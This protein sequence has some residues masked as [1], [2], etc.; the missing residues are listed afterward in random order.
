MTIWN[1]RSFVI[2]SI[3]ITIITRGLVILRKDIIDQATK[4]R[5]DKFNLVTQKSRMRNSSSQEGHAAG[6][7]YGDT[8]NIG[9]V[10]GQDKREGLN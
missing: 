2:I 3:R 5:D 9:N 6:S 1:C 4:H 10:V 7:R 8:V